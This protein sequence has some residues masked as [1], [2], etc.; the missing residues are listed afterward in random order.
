VDTT[1]RYTRYLWGPL[2]GAEEQHI[3]TA[4]EAPGQLIMYSTSWCGYCHTLKRQLID[5]GITFSEVNI[6]D[7]EGAADLVQTINHGLRTVPTL[8]F[9]D[10]TSLTNPR[11]SQVRAHL[12][13]IAS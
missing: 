3:V 4:V 11:L 9:P 6:E 5:A 13:G 8:V 2:A 1:D 7:V 10:G 12:D